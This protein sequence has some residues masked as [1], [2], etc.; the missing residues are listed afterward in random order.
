M[1]FYPSLTDSSFIKIDDDEE[2]IKKLMGN[3]P[4]F[5]NLFQLNLQS[6]KKLNIP[7]FNFGGF[8]K[9][10]HKRTERVFMPYTF[11]TLPELEI[12]TVQEFLK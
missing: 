5:T 7:A 12:K 3:A 9:D 6:I 10:A 4:A 2:S 8:G 11:K 1:N